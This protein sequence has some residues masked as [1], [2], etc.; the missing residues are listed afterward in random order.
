MKKFFVLGLN[1]N[2]QHGKDTAANIINN[3]IMRRSSIETYAFAKPFKD[4]L[5]IMLNFSHEQLYGSLK[6]EIDVTYGVTPRVAMTS[7]GTEWG[8]N[9][10]NQDIWLIR[11]NQEIEKAIDNGHDGIIITDV[12]YDNEAEMIR[13]WDNV[14]YENDS[15]R[16]RVTAKIL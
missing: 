6:T 12:R 1:A 4:A 15:D 13:Q 16:T 9:M 7:L 11:A 5:Q 14:L 2:A 3:S 10:I 8:R